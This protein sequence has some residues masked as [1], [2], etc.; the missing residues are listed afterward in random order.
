MVPSLGFTVNG[1]HKL[2]SRYT[3]NLQA[4]ASAA[5][6]KTYIFYKK[7]VFFLLTNQ[8]FGNST[9]FPRPETYLDRLGLPKSSRRV[10]SKPILSYQSPKRTKNC[11]FSSKFLK[12]VDVCLKIV[13]TTKNIFFHLLEHV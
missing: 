10:G 7:N 4:Y 13:K 8:L 3:T 2:E 9:A 1:Q 5:D 12:I 6:P 11:F